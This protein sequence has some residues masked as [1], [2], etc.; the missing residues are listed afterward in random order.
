METDNINKRK[1]DMKRSLSISPLLQANVQ[2]HRLP[3]ET[4]P[5]LHGVVLLQLKLKQSEDSADSEQKFH[6]SQVTTNTG[7]RASAEGDEGGLLALS[8]TLGVPALRNELVGI[9][10]PD[11]RET[12]DSV[13]GNG[14]DVTGVEDMTGDVDG[15]AVGGDLAGETHGG[16]TVDTHGFPDD[17]LEAVKMLSVNP[18][19]NTRGW[20]AHTKESP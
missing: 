6:L 4:L 13:A 3:Q 9:R 17:P 20:L 1:R 18:F 10:T 14:D 16:G 5:G 11:L 7:T 15:A 8:E 19:H 12:V 2:G